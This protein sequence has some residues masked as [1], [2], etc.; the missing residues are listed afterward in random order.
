MFL[1]TRRLPTC[2][3]CTL[4]SLKCPSNIVFVLC[5]MVLAVRE[6]LLRLPGVIVFSVTQPPDEVLMTHAL[7]GSLD[8]MIENTF[9][10]KFELPLNELR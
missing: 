10:L 1:C 7:S 4:G 2:W 6:V 5:H 3:H 9:Y 8:P